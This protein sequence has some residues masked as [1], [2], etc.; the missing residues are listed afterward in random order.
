MTNVSCFFSEF[1]ATAVL[2]IV[3]LAT[4]DK[5]NAPPPPGLL[6]L[7]LFIVILGLGACLGMETGDCAHEIC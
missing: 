3:V 2:V 7:V 1:F 5:G 6:P 4:T